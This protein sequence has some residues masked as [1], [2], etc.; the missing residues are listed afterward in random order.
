MTF[1][2]KKEEVLEIKLTSYGKHRLAAGTFKPAYYAFFDDDV[3]Y[4]GA[5]AGVA[6]DNNDIEP[7]IQ[8]NCPS[9]RAQTSFRDL[10]KEVKR[11]T[12]DIEKDVLHERNVNDL[13]NDP[14]I[15]YD[16]DGL[17]N[18]LPLGNSQPGNQYIAA[19]RVELLAGSYYRSRSTTLD[20]ALTCS[21]PYPCQKPIINI[22]QIDIDLIITPKIIEKDFIGVADPKTE[23]YVALNSATNRFIRIEDDYLLLD[24]AEYNVDLLN[25]SFEVEVYEITTEEEEEVLVPKFFRKKIE[26]IRNDIMLDDEEVAAQISEA[27]INKNYVEY[28]FNIDNDENI[29]GKTKYEKIISREKKGNIFDNNV[30]YEDYSQTPG[31]ELYTSDNDGEEC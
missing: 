3:L 13:K 8:E 26:L 15:F 4:D 10:E 7:R 18:V 30:G 17:R 2:N 6:E 20:S 11:Q 12:H 16:T 24:I 28:Y 29:D 23:K 1:F 22:P 9:L 14:S 27:R 25:D 31:Q 21:V 19:W 5:R